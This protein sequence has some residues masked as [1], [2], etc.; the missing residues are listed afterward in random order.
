MN[1]IKQA[2]NARAI[3]HDTP[4]SGTREE[5]PIVDSEAII[6]VTPGEPH[7]QIIN[8]GFPAG[9]DIA[10]I[11]TAGGY[12]FVPADQDAADQLGIILGTPITPDTVINTTVLMNESIEGSDD[13]GRGRLTGN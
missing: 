7:A 9:I 5:F 10:A 2:D 13:S 11:P 3:Q 1:A 8:E 6:L 12:I 4:I